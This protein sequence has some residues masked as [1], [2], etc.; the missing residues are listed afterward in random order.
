VLPAL[1]GVIEAPGSRRPTM[2]STLG[3]CFSRDR[4][5]SASPAAAFKSN[6]RPGAL[7]FSLMF[8]FR[9]LLPGRAQEANT[10]IDA[11]DQS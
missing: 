9:L 2:A 11:G 10:P 4:L 1:W 5:F 3:P 8:L 7:I 6:E